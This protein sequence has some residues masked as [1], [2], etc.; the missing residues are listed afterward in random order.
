MKIFL[1][2]ILGFTLS[3]SFSQGVCHKCEVIREKNKHLPP[4]EFEFYDDYLKAEKEKKVSAFEFLDDSE[5]ADKDK[6]VS[7]NP[8]ETLK[9]EKTGMKPSKEKNSVEES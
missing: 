2:L 3:A 6:K 4:P 7:A 1:M 9:K 5:K 8:K